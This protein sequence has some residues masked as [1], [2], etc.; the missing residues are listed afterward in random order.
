MT[1]DKS[2]ISNF[3]FEIEPPSFIFHLS[4]DICH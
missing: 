3:K 4:L 1:N 2:Q